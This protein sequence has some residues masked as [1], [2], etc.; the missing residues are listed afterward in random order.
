[1]Y[2]T[3]LLPLVLLSSTAL[4]TT[5]VGLREKNVFVIGADSK[6]TYRGKGIKGPETACKIYQSG[7]IYFAIAG[8]A[9]DR[10]TDFFPEKVVANSFPAS[11]SF[12][13]GLQSMERALSNSLT[14]EM[15]RLKAEYRE[16]F[17]YLQEDE[18]DAFTVLVAEM[19]QDRPI[20]AGRGF[21]YIDDKSPK[22]VIHRRSC[23]GD[24]PDG[25]YVFFA[26]NQEAA[27]KR[28]AEFYKSHGTV[29][30]PSEFVEELVDAEVRGS[31]EEVGPP[32]TILRVDTQGAH[33]ISNDSSCPIVVPPAR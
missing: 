10:N 32:I 14:T 24:C 16:T 30:S 15:R 5:L 25:E 7:P 20:M 9:Y 28:T 29:T 1:M 12:D 6:V 19:V 33:W 4:A 21:K 8:L 11:I 31:P 22:V 13:S 3:L 23:P 27:R 18:G 2:K 26:G 17:D